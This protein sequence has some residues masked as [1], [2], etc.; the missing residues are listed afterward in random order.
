MTDVG[1]NC[2]GFFLGRQD[3]N[4]RPS[5]SVGSLLVEKW[6]R[7]S[8]RAPPHTKTWRAM[9]ANN[10]TWAAAKSITR[11]CRSG[12]CRH[13]EIPVDDDSGENQFASTPANQPDGRMLAVT[14]DEAISS[15]GLCGWRRMVLLQE[16]RGEALCCF[17]VCNRSAFRSVGVLRS[18]R[19][20]MRTSTS[21]KRQNVPRAQCS[22]YRDL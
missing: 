4:G 8:H 15:R 12:L 3:E 17:H 20:A 5:S 2:R 22:R 9:V 19:L 6:N 7:D 1:W 21:T 18:V 11:L 16:G 14:M 13:L 10:T